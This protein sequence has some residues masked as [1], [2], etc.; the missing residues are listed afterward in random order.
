MRRTSCLNLHA[1]NATVEPYEVVPI[2]MDMIL[3]D[4]PMG[5]KDKYWCQLT[6]ELGGGR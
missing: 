6:S 2:A 4:E 3:L 5:S 1:L